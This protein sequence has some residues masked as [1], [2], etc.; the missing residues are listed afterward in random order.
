MS[1]SVL[2]LAVLFCLLSGGCVPSSRL[3]NPDAISAPRV[4][5]LATGPMAAPGGES[6]RQ[7]A[8]GLFADVYASL[9][10]PGTTEHPDIVRGSRAGDPVPVSKDYFIPGQLLASWTLDTRDDVWSDLFGAMRRSEMSTDSFVVPLMKDGVAVT[11]FDVRLD[12][13]GRWQTTVTLVD[14]LP[15]GRVHDL[16]VATASL[17]EL[18]GPGTAVRPVLFLPS[19]LEFAVGKNGDR[20]AAVYLGFV[21]YG[22]G[23]AGFNEYLPETGGVFTTSELRKLLD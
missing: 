1:R 23:V 15:A 20:E 13:D 18:L 3:W 21:N 17:E 11:E 10:N 19:G 6:P 7:A 9:L 14:P 5:V 4:S 16:Q 22:P 12:E 8:T 2:V